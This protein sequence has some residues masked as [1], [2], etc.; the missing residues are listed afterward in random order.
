MQREMCEIVAKRGRFLGVVQRWTFIA[1]A[2]AGFTLAESPPFTSAAFKPSDGKSDRRAFNR[3]LAE[4]TRD[5][6]QPVPTVSARPGD[7]WWNIQLWRSS[8]TV[9]PSNDQGSQELG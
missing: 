9:A 5:G 2:T 7:D 4:L 8:L 6:W 3:L 1:V